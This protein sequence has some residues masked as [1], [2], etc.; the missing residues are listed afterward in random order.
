[1]SKH[2]RRP[3][4]ITRDPETAAE[5]QEA[6]TAAK[7]A[8][9]LDDCRMYGLLTGGPRVNRERCEWVIAEGKNRGI[10]PAP[11]AALQLIKAINTDAEERKHR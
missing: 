5:W 11:D 8:L 4:P 10:E 2:A 7:G 6:V 9:D 3:V 1:M